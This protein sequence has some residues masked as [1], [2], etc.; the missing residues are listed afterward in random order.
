MILGNRGKHLDV[1]NPWS[2]PSLDYSIVSCEL[3]LFQLFAG[4]L[5]ERRKEHLGATLE[6]SKMSTHA[7][8]LE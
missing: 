3:S 1:T 5:E 4:A 7:V 8:N 6:E 2:K